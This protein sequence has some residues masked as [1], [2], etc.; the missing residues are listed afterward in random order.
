M[1][2]RKRK[3]QSSVNLLKRLVFISSMLFSSFTVMAIVNMDG[4]HFDHKKDKFTAA[5]D[6]TASG[7]S[8]NQD[9]TKAALN[10][11]L[12]WIS[13]KSINL[14]ILGY[15]YGE[16]N[17]VR[18]VN[19]AFFHYRYIYQVKESMDWEFFGQVEQNEFT[20]LSFRGLVGTGLRF[21][22]L[23]SE[24]HRGFLGAGG[25]YSTEQTD[26]TSGLTD[27]GTEEFVRANFYFLSKYKLNPT[28]S[29]SNV[30]YYQPRLSHFSDYRALLESKLDFK[31]HNDLSL[32]L[33]LDLEHDSEPP[34]SIESTDISYM[35]GLIFKF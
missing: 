15:Q 27:D 5:V 16:T 21:S 25:F 35:T 1:F 12:N 32:R 33:S 6:L 7:S 8:G 22:V 23:K 4:L 24:N 17:Q 2:P 28:I 18:S 19:K 30:F 26:V 9:S 10:A 13:D 20:R 14:A 29:F 11:Q 3:Y 31:I 34:Q